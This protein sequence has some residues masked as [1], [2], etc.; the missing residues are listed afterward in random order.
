MSLCV[1]IC[2]HK[3]THIHILLQLCILFW[4]IFFTVLC[5]IIV[6]FKV[7]E[8]FIYRR[9]DVVFIKL[10]CKD[11]NLCFFFIRY[12]WRW[13]VEYILNIIFKCYENK[14]ILCFL[15]TFP[16]AITLTEYENVQ[17]LKRKTRKCVTRSCKKKKIIMIFQIWQNNF[18]KHNTMINENLDEICCSSFS[19]AKHFFA[20][21]FETESD[22][23]RPFICFLHARWNPSEFLEFLHFCSIYKQL[24]TWNFIRNEIKTK[25]VDYFTWAMGNKMNKWWVVSQL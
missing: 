15:F 9:H 17:R 7:T 6:C 20:R 1:A 3:N 13:S 23:N 12:H 11:S 18:S 14:A 16:F 4:S 22:N 8:L 19:S 21:C 24:W 10:H 2:Q 5:K 25:F